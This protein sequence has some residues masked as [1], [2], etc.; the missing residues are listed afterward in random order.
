MITGLDIVKEQI[1]IAAGQPLSITQKEVSRNGHAIECRIN[2]ELP[3]AD[4]RPCPGQIARWD[5]PNMKDVRVD[6]HCY[7]GYFVPPYYDSLLAKLCTKGDDRPQAIALMEAAL[8]NFTVSGIDTTIPLYDSIMKNPEY[9]D[10]RINTRWVEHFLQRKLGKH[11]E[12]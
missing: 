4:F 12:D 6:S 8:A 9:R 10:G 11:E 2:A 1:T 3:E 7:T 5:P